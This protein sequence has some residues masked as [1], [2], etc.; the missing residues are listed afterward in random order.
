[1]RRCGYPR[2][3]TL[4]LYRLV[5]NGLPPNFRGSTTPGQDTDLLTA[6]FFP[7]CAQFIEKPISAASFEEVEKVRDALKQA[8]GVVSMG[9]MLRYLK[10]ESGPSNMIF[11]L[12]PGSRG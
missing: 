8:G 10:G 4:A 9:Y 12:T 6:K 2:V 11:S 7:G 5:V 3:L 1:M